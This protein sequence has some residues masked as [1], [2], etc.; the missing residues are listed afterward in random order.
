MSIV[1]ANIQKE[2]PQIR[3]IINHLS[4][5]IA[6]ISYVVERGENVPSSLELDLDKIRRRNINKLRK[7]ET[8]LQNLKEA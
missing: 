3:A 8:K 7:L 5:A 2:I 1:D 6:R 4:E